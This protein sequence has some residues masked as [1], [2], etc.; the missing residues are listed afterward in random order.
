MARQGTAKELDDETGL[1]YY[2]ARYLDPRYSMWISTD[3]ALGEYIPKAP[4]NEETKRYNQNLPGMGGI[5][6]HINSNLYHYAG[7]NPIRYIDPNGREDNKSQYTLEEVYFFG[8]GTI[9]T[10]FDGYG[11]SFDKIVF[12]D[13]VQIDKEIKNLKIQKHDQYNGVTTTVTKDT[14]IFLSM[15]NFENT[16]EDIE[17]IKNL[18]G[19][20]YFS[21][22]KAPDQYLNKQRSIYFYYVSE[23]YYFYKD[24]ES[25]KQYLLDKNY[26]EVAEI[27]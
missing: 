26:N 9:D 25:G 5:F 8:Y 19:T 15:S 2:G 11:F 1:Y 17:L 13:S 4:I 20:I 27:E 3:P 14:R 18:T 7:N 24:E 6:N 21:N 16:V 23:K 10:K 22:Q 12:G